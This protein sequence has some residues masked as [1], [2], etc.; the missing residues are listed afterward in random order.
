MLDKILKLSPAQKILLYSAMTSI[1]VQ[2]I[3]INLYKPVHMNKCI[4]YIVFSF[5]SLIC[6]YKMIVD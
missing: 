2:V 4:G 3:F 1:T 5:L 6:Y